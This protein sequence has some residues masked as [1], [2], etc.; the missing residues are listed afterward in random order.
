MQIR[1]TLA[2]L[3]S[4]GTLDSTQAEAFFESLLKGQLDDAQ[5]GA[6]LALIARRRPT[7]DE[8]LGG[9]R[10]M[11]RHVTRIPGVETLAGQIL[12]TCGTGGAKKTFNVSTIAAIV[13]AAAGAG[14]V[15]VAK[16]GNKGRSGRG[17]AEMLRTLGVNI[18]AGPAAQARCLREAGVCFCFAI[19]H[20]PAMR[21][22][23]R[24]R[25]SLGFPTIF[26]AL[27]PLTNP[28]GAQRQLMGVYE[29]GLVEQ[30]ARVLAALGSRRAIVAHGRDG[31]DE[32]STSAPTLI[33][34]V[35]NGAVALEEFDAC[36]HGIPRATLADLQA[37]DLD[38]AGAIAMEILRGGAGPKRDMVL[39]NAAAALM[40]GDVAPTFEAGLQAS[41]EAIDSGA[42][43]RTFEL[44]ARL[45]NEG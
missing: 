42:A 13:V 20:H 38:D 8:L 33:A 31:I 18:D 30:N 2:L 28:A 4:G 10:A 9:A 15:L 35:E 1:E 19:H 5:I 43:R 25:Q 29:P 37:S 45:S 36:A 41:R 26:N 32:I 3:L 39:V 27:G 40:A 22:A 44:L 14:K 16:H 7:T 23:A 24:A 12:D 17:S 6:A 21:H 34:R 11:R